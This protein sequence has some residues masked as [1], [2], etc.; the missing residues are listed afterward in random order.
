KTKLS[1]SSTRFVIQNANGGVKATAFFLAIASKRY[2]TSTYCRHKELAYFLKRSSPESGRVIQIHLD[3][4]AELPL[5]KSLGVPFAIAKDP[6]HPGRQEYKDRL[7]RV[8]EPIVNELD[9][10]YAESKMI[11]LAWP[12]G[13]RFLEGWTPAMDSGYSAKRFDGNRGNRK[14]CHL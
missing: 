7:Q 6:L 4:S 1:S 12:A 10:A 2:N 5:P 8:Y 11:F 13:V 3:L 9:K 14:L